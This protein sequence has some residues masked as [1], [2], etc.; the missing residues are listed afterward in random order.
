MNPITHALAA[1]LVPDVD[2]LG[3]ARR[4]VVDTLR[5]RFA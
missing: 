4:A 3:A 1:G 2:G 5:R